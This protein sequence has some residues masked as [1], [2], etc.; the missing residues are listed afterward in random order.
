MQSPNIVRNDV[1]RSGQQKKHLKWSHIPI[2]HNILYFYIWVTYLVLW[3]P[4]C[5][6]FVILWSLNVPNGLFSFR[7]VLSSHCI[8]QVEGREE[9]LFL[10]FLSFSFNDGL[11]FC[12]FSC[13]FFSRFL[14][15]AY[16][17]DRGKCCEW[18][19]LTFLSA[20]FFYEHYGFTIV[21][22]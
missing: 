15:C 4:S 18:R 10:V 11:H 2:W 3:H 8:M 19:S 21:T 7:L 1:T 22:L 13:Q 14:L 6:H 16:V 20:F 12:L 5:R 9:T 17:Y